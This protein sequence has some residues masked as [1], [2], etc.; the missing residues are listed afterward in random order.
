MGETVKWQVLDKIRLDSPCTVAVSDF[1]KGTG[2]ALHLVPGRPP[3]PE[4]NNH[5]SSSLRLFVVLPHLQHDNFWQQ[6]RDCFYTSR[7]VAVEG[8]LTRHI[9]EEPREALVPTPS[10]A[11]SSCDRIVPLENTEE[12]GDLMKLCLFGI[13][14]IKLWLLRAFHMS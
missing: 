4:V 14:L 9:L 1:K 10:I 6:D 8:R 3:N 11:A 7:Q 12:G 13:P 5:L 2:T